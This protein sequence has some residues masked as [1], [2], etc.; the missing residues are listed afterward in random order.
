MMAEARDLSGMRLA[1]LLP[2]GAKLPPG[3]EVSIRGLALDS[4]GV[5][6]GYLF[7]ACKG[8]DH[9]GLAHLTDARA[10]GAVAVF[11]DPDGAAPYM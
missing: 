2:G 9:H 1:N 10:R 5:G 7:L 3:G 4:R 11:Y 8:H 6:A